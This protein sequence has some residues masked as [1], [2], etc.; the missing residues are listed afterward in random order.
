MDQIM[1]NMFQRL[2]DL[3]LKK[4]Q[5]VQNGNPPFSEKEDKFVSDLV[6]A[7]RRSIGNEVQVAALGDDILNTALIVLNTKAD[8]AA[9][10]WEKY[11]L[12]PGPKKK[13]SLERLR[14]LILARLQNEAAQSGSGVAQLAQVQARDVDRNGLDMLR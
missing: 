4:R 10:C 14:P 2:R 5:P 13:Y 9:Y 7:G 3:F 6:A 12:R 1:P 8:P 11:D